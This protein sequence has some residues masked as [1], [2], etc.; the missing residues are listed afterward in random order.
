MQIANGI[1]GPSA[2]QYDGPAGA[3]QRGHAG[4]IGDL[5]VPDQQACGL[6]R[7]DAGNRR[8]LVAAAGQVMDAGETAG[9]GRQDAGGCGQ[10]VETETHR[11]QRLGQGQAAHDM[12]Q[13]DLSA[14]IG[15]D[16][17]PAAL[18]R[19]DRAAARPASSPAIRDMVV[20]QS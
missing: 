4:S 16:R 20:S 18:P 13:A 10:P 17:D 14:A 7:Q 9:T 6:L 19:H 2:D 11:M 3:A 1:A 12:A 15:A 5:P 8:A